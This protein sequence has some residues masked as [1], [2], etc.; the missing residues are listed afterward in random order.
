M[1]SMFV[2]ASLS[3]E[4]LSEAGINLYRS[5]C[6]DARL[7]LMSPWYVPDHDR[8]C[9]NGHICRFFGTSTTRPV[10]PPASQVGDTRIGARCPTVNDVVSHK[11]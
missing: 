7:L 5:Q 3:F 9:G 2:P 4:G 8:V 11:G 10:P 6:G 1:T